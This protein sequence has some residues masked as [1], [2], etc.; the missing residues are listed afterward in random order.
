MAWTG[1]YAE[2]PDLEFRFETAALNG[3]GVWANLYNPRDVPEALESLD[4]MQRKLGLILAVVFMLMVIGAIMLARRNF[5]AGRGDGRS[6]IRLA[7]TVFAIGMLGWVV[8]AHHI[9]GFEEVVLL[10]FGFAGATGAAGIARLA[11]STDI[12][13]RR[14]MC[15]VSGS[16]SR[17][18]ALCCPWVYTKGGFF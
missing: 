8:N 14:Q 9:F 18:E 6:A 2:Q 10:L 5:R 12:R 4:S 11:Y 17:S 3:K 15:S 7:L 16:D 1:T 13:R